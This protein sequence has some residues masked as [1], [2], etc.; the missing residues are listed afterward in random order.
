MFEPMR[1]RPTI[2]NCMP[3]S[4]IVGHST[5]STL[6]NLLQCLFHS[7]R[8]FSQASFHVPAKMHTQ[9]SSAAIGEHLKIASSLPALNNPNRKLLPRH[10]QV[11]RVVAGN[12]K[13][14]SRIRSALVRLAR[15]MQK[16]RSE[17]EARSHAFLVAH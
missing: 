6:I 13:E 3:C 12:L 5:S 15:R 9:S 4:L 16:A 1:P 2:P 14:P 8:Q 17:T 11:D 7:C 10:G